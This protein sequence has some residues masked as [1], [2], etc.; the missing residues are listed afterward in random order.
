MVEQDDIFATS[1]QP[2][3]RL[4]WLAQEIPVLLVDNI[5]R[6]PARVRNTALGLSYEP[7]T[8]LY[9]G[10]VA[11]LPAG[12]APMI[13]FLRKVLALVNR[14]YLPNLPA[15]PGGR[16]LTAIRSM[17]TDFAILDLHPEELSP[18][19]RRPHI[20]AVPLFGLIYLNEEDRGGTL[21]FRQKSD[22]MSPAAHKGYQVASDEHVE[23]CGRIEGRFNRLA[24]YPGFVLHS[25][26]VKGDWIHGDARFESP[27]LTQRLQFLP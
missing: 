15:L 3:A 27:R 19:Q 9:P 24:I 22:A 13:A 7:G 12:D 4:E 25:G 6:D 21:F 2:T 16:R 5:Y 1:S 18:Q 11:R 17:D 10:R 14:H 23:L 8:A 20:D 26:E